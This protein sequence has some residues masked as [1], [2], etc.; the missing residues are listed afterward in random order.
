MTSDTDHRLVTQY[1][2]Q[3]DAAAGSLT[4]ARRAILREE[5]ANHLRELV[6]PDLS[7]ADASAA[8]SSFGSPADILGQELDVPPSLA[9]SQRRQRR[10]RR[11]VAIVVSAVAAAILLIVLLPLLFVV[12][13]VPVAGPDGEVTSVVNANPQ[14][15]ARV[16]TGTGYFEY[17]AAIEAMEDPLPAGAA[18]PAGVPEGLDSGTSS[19]G[20]MQSG[21]G[22]VVAQYT[23][24]CAWESE[25]LTA[26]AQEATG[27]QVAAEAMLTTWST[28]EFY[29][30]TDP[31]RG[32]VTSVLEPVWFGDSSGVVRDQPQSCSQAGIINVRG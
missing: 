28:S 30:T 13:P 7:D 3:F 6:Q 16:T 32:W 29:T 14:G 5:I 8:L 23:W 9:A 4:N 18:Y 27:R 20:V 19:T 2:R 11:T 25:Y 21:A 10:V 12:A 22:Y 1:L 26:M 15:P 24:L 17:Q 31:N